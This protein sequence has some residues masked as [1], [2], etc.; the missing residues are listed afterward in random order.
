MS[1]L[2]LGDVPYGGA[3]QEVL[4]DIGQEVAALLAERHG[5]D[6]KAA[7]G[8]GME[9]ALRV[10]RRWCGV[11]VYFPR[12]VLIDEKHWQMYQ[13]FTGDNHREL[14]LRHGMSEQWVYKIVARM[15][16]VDFSRRQEDMFPPEGG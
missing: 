1:N 16:R 3:A 13:E 6:K 7:A 15:R 10:A 9:A 5:L 8:A 14:A 12:G 2:P 11:T 4:A